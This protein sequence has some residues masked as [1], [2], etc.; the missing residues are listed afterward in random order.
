MNVDAFC[1]QHF[2]RD[3]RTAAAKNLQEVRGPCVLAELSTVHW[4]KEPSDVLCSLKHVVPKISHLWRWPSSRC[5]VWCN[6]SVHLYPLSTA[7]LDRS[8]LHA[9][10]DILFSVIDLV[11]NELMVL[12]RDAIFVFR[13]FND[14]V[15]YMCYTFLNEMRRLPLVVSR[16]QMSITQCLR[17]ALLR[18]IR[19][20]GLSSTDPGRQTQWVILP[21]QTHH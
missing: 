21:R 7:V 12:A 6:S 1:W 10:A 16:M 13:L 20:C 4:N 17:T 18:T 9:L 3:T 19:L 15:Q 11:H 8:T 14:A 2:F 5:L